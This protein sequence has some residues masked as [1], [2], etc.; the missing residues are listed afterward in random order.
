M[1]IGLIL[2][3]ISSVFYPQNF[4]I[5]GVIKNSHT[6]EIL[7]DANLFLEEIDKGTSSDKNGKFIFQSLSGGSYTLKI[8]YIGFETKKLSIDLDID[9]E[10]IVELVEFPIMLNNTVIEGTS[11]KFRETSVAFSEITSKEIEYK[12]GSREAVNILQETPSSY[13]SS[14]GG[15]I[16]EQRLSLRG[17]DQT[18]IAVMINGIPINNPENGQIYWSNWVGISDLVEYVQVQRGLGAIPYSIAA[19]GG[20]V[21]FVTV[22]SSANKPSYLFK[23]E[24]GAYNL[25]KSSL[26]FSTKLSE[27]VSLIGLVSRRT[28]D[29]YADQVYSDEYNYYFGIGLY[30]QKHVLEIQLFGSPQ[31]HGQRLTPQTITDWNKFGK[32]YNADWGYLNGKALN[33]RDNEFHNPTLNI[34]YNWQIN[35]YLF[36]NNIISFSRGYGGGTV[37]PWYPELTRNESGQ[38]DFDKEYLFNSGNIDTNFDPQKN[39]SLIALRK[40]VHKNYWGNIISAFKYNF[41]D[42]IF[43]AGFDLKY[44]EAQNYNELSN[45]LGG[46]YVIGSSNVNENPNRMMILRDKVDFN[47]DSFTKNYGL[48]TQAE[49]KNND[50]SLY[51][52]IGF[53]NTSYNRIDYFNFLKNDTRRETGWNNFSGSIVKTGINYNINENNNVFVNFGSFSRAPLSMNVY[54]YANN[55]YENIKNERIS[56]FELGYGYQ[57]DFM[58]LNANYFNT[59]WDDK[60]F[61]QSYLSSDNTEL[62]YYNIFG[63]SA[64]HT[65]I[66]IDGDIDLTKNF[67][68]NSMFSY[69][70][71]KWTSDV[72]AYIRPESNPNDEIKYH[73]YTNGLYVGNYPMT[74]A[75]LGILFKNEISQNITYY[76][77]PIYNFYGRYY[78]NYYPELRTSISSKGVQPWRI[79]D[80]SNVDI[81]MG[82]NYKFEDVFIKSLN[83]SFNIFNLLNHQSIIDATDGKEHNSNS[84]LV[85]YGSER[86]WSASFSVAL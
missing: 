80:F 64:H 57:N 76:L 10:I 78:A 47:A 27:N 12:L 41:N 52:N 53:S 66:E 11:P 28:G 55:L 19:V 48:F 18:N 36:L 33:L 54:D 13:V 86:W 2:L 59:I 31:K 20:S 9:Q 83:L 34:K 35:N 25:F 3:F 51:L 22:G 8:S 4:N 72:D 39:R 14:Q 44:Y 32:K 81:H 38:I 70:V 56:S 46:D 68:I 23:E 75:S 84:A 62:Y 82:I 65:G 58:K 21:N 6:G 26:S 50:L 40:G 17:F 1:K 7:P 73:S 37:P 74:S 30:L 5:S 61:S 67:I 43:T 24:I 45:L 79:P 49:Y 29:G 69:S 42:F 15:G 16:G 85:W 77:N 71:N 60:A 63:A